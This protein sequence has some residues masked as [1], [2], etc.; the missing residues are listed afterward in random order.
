MYYFW[1]CRVGVFAQFSAEQVANGK[2]AKVV[3]DH[4]IAVAQS[5]KGGGKADLAN[6]TIP[7]SQTVTAASLLASARSSVV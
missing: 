5:G 4:L 1:C 7:V 6:A 2:S 3:C